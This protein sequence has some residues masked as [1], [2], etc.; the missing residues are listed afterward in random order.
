MSWDSGFY[1]LEELSNKIEE[2]TGLIQ[3]D[4]S[5][6][7]GQINARLNNVDAQISSIIQKFN[8]NPT[9]G[10]D[11]E[12]G[13]TLINLPIVD[14]YF[15]TG[16][17]Q[18]VNVES[19]DYYTVA[20]M[21]SATEIGTYTIRLT[22]RDPEKYAWVDSDERSIQIG[23]SIDKGRLARPIVNKDFEAFY[24]GEK[25]QVI[26]DNVTPQL[27][28]NANSD[29]PYQI[30]AGEYTTIYEIKDKNHYCWDDGSEGKVV[31]NWEIQK[32]I[33]TPTKIEKV[34]FGVKCLT[35]TVKLEELEGV[36]YTIVDQPN[37][38]LCTAFLEGTTLELGAA[39]T[40]RSGDTRIGIHATEGQNY[41]DFIFYI[42]IGCGFPEIVE[43]TDNTVPLEKIEDMLNCHYQGY[44]NIEDYWDVG[45]QRQA[46]DTNGF[47][48]DA[49]QC[50]PCTIEGANYDN[51]E[52]PKQESVIWVILDFNQYNLTTPVGARTKNAVT[53]GYL[54][55]IGS[56]PSVSIGMRLHYDE[57]YMVWTN[58]EL[59]GY[60]NGNF[61]NSLQFKD[62][63][64]QVSVP[65]WYGPASDYCFLPALME[66]MGSQPDSE[67]DGAQLLSYYQISSNR[68]K[69][70][71][72]EAL[73][74]E[75]VQ[76]YTR[77]MGTGG[78]GYNRKYDGNQ[79]WHYGYHITFS[80]AQSQVNP[81]GRYPISPMCCL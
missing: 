41:Q 47:Q 68:Q 46:N 65:C 76:Y 29:Y 39:A 78:S 45:D 48:V 59:R 77:T 73:S 74:E 35:K 18:T 38:N 44:L 19:N 71:G 67:G 5:D 61:Y 63:V 49:H 24:T 33:P 28:H 36:E 23:W 16:D 8:E 22:L 20:G 11:P 40:G 42:E 57:Y 62:L 81:T 15:Y 60:L 3:T 66:I 1:L 43:F 79:S 4:I 37:P 26:L 31:L 21:T 25:I 52:V 30:N 51:G 69:K 64:K 6:F 53:I 13:K 9:G 80:T 54:G 27:K 12:T 75:I 32:A 72:W 56:S 58:Q 70:G 17:R 34:A 7:K 10:S 55:T 50:G 2:S 14:M